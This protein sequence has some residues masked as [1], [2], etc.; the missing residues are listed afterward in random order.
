M[1][2]SFTF[3]GLLALLLLFGQ[4]ST[5]LHALE[6]LPGPSN[7]HEPESGYC[8]VH[9]HDGHAHAHC[10]GI[11]HLHD[12]HDAA[13]TAH[14]EYADCLVFHLYGNLSAAFQA[15]D[16]VAS[17]FLSAGNAAE[18]DQSLSDAGSHA[19]Y[20]IRAPPIVA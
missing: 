19:C 6:H 20:Q 11:E 1:R 7:P 12:A 2:Q 10:I 17:S 15:L 3:H 8:H 18:C 16:P 9:S 5:L 4:Y 14:S 13:E